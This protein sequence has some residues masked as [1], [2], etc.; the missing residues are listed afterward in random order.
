MLICLL[1]I[2]VRM[3]E[4]FVKLLCKYGELSFEIVLK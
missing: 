3:G 2:E 4:E 1:L